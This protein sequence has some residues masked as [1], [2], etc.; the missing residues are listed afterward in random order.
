MDFKIRMD[1]LVL[2]RRPDLVLINKKK[3]ILQSRGFYYADKPQKVNKRKQK[4][5]QILGPC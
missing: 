1:Y 3:K 2:A 4:D 5:R